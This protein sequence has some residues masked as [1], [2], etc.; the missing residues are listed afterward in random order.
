MRRTKQPSLAL[1]AAIMLTGLLAGQ[2]RLVG[3]EA[4]AS[5]PSLVI[6]QLKITS[7]NGQ[8]I[9]LYNA[10]NTTLDMGKYQLEYFNS[11]DL[12][13]ATSSKLISLTGLVPP[14]GY[15][16]VSDSSQLLCYQL[17]VDS[18]SLG[19]SS[20]AGMVE[21]LAYNQ[22]G[23]GG[24]AT[25]VLQDFVGWSKTAAAGAQTLPSNANAFLERQPVDSKNNPVITTPGSGSW[26][27][28]QPSSDGCSLVAS[29]NSAPVKTGFGQ[30]LP[31]IEPPATFTSQ[32]D[33]LPTTYQ[34]Q[35][36]PLITEI[37]PNPA[38]TG[39]DAVDEFIEVYN[40]NPADFDLS[41]FSLQAGT[42]S[43]HTFLIPNG[44]ILPAQSFTTFYADTTHLSLSNTGGQVKLLD[45]TGSIIGSTDTYGTA[46]DGQAW[47]L[48]NGKWYW[49]TQPTPGE[50]NIINQPASKPAAKAKASVTK[51]GSTKKAAT[52]KTKVTKA[53]AV[54][55]KKAKKPKTTTKLASTADTTQASPIPIHS[56]T[57]AVIVSLAL[58][59]GAYEYRSDLANR[60]HE[61]RRNI[62]FGRKDRKQT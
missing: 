35:M 48:A 42:T 51:A 21:V 12:A 20:T 18:V 46:N 49:T 28:V 52:A 24:S 17:T 39:N 31:P 60:F 14:H 1:I 36:A 59:Y 5:G 57:L 54:K 50:P 2:F 4:D 16:M 40:P 29:S 58:L 7:A 43:L 61:F 8:F 53:K 23:P 55:S 62:K 41:G 56:S 19:L 3:V 26:Q 33:E 10:S 32:V 25:P 27:G 13:K 30:L 6:S 44:T 11:F 9:T 22:S 15:F 37:L 47:A 34:G 45:P 38:G